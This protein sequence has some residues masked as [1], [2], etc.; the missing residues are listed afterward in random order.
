MKVQDAEV[1]YFN[2]MRAEI[3]ILRPHVI[4]FFSGPNYD[5][6][7][8]R[9]LGGAK[10]EKCLDSGLSMR[11]L[12]IVK[13]DGL[14][15]DCLAL[16]TYHPKYLNFNHELKNRI[17]QVMMQRIGEVGQGIVSAGTQY[18][19]GHLKANETR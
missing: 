11:Q 4:V 17:W 1:R 6:D 9:R 10:F 16:R 8:L 3:D 14:N 5:N 18:N 13:I 19:D 12:A 15:F 2:V 7:I